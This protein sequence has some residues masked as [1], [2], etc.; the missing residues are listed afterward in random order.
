[1][2]HPSRL[3]TAL[4]C[5]V[6]VLNCTACSLVPLWPGAPVLPPSCA[7]EG[8]API[9]PAEHSPSLPEPAASSAP[10]PSD[11][12]PSVPVPSDPAPSDPAAPMPP[13][14]P[15]PEPPL[16]TYDFSRPAPESPAVDNSYFADAAFVGDSRT[17][18]FLLFSGVKNGRNITANG[19]SIFQLATKECIPVGDTLH[20]PLEV[21]AQAE[22][23]KVYLSLGI[24]E[25]GYQ[26]DQGFYQAYCQAIDAIRDCQPGAVIYIQALIPLNEEKIAASGGRDYL[27]N[28]HLRIYNDLMR[29]VAEE[30]QVVFLDL[31]SAFAQDGALPYDAS[32]DG[33]HLSVEY[34][35]KWLE[36][37]RHHTVDFLTL[38][39]GGVS[40]VTP[41]PESR[42]E[43]APIH[44]PA[45]EV[46]PL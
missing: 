26:N 32:H 37:L 2:S 42:P 20:T 21:L 24:N 18:G 14:L 1:M 22:Y 17:D 27:E 46:M 34:Y 16:S 19:L 25:L 8:S 5:A 30:K 12:A 43:P 11:P 3:F 4:L 13:S 36:Y 15:E 6:L 7:P 33:V 35:R 40:Q 45:S 39:P 9:A 31:Y 10:P 29:Q 41:L 38:Y 28:D 23:G 44:K